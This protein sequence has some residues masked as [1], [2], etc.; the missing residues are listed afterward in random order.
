ML[1]SKILIDNRN[2]FVDPAVNVFKQLNHL[3]TI[4]QK[5]IAIDLTWLPWS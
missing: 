1:I 4:N 2:R 5:V 3:N